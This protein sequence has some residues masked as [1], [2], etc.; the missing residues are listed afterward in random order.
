M[1]LALVLLMLS[2]LLLMLGLLLGMAAMAAGVLGLVWLV[3]AWRRA[4]PMGAA[5]VPQP[6]DIREAPLPALL[7]QTAQW[8]QSQTHALPAPAAALAQDIG[9]QLTALSQASPAAP[10][11]AALRQIASDHLPELIAAY[12][13]VPPDQ[14]QTPHAGAT[15]NEQLTTALARLQ[16]EIAQLGAQTSGEALDRLAVQ[17]RF[18]DY[19]YEG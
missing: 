6:V 8:V 7:D 12:R 13:A 2:P 18:I 16:G 1:V 11:A 19:R 4:G 17:A 10:Q 14:R 9:A 3:R 15:P 5:P